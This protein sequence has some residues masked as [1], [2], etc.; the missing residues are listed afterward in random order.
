MTWLTP[1]AGLILAAVVIPPLVLLYFLKLRRK[2]QPIASTFLWKRAIEDLRANAPFQRLRRSILLLLQLIALI[3]LA[4]SLMQ[5]QIQGGDVDRGKVVILIDHSASMSAADVEDGGT[6]LDEAKRQARGYIESLYGGGIFASTN[7]EAMVIAFSDRAEIMCRFTGSRALLLDAVDRIEQT[8]GESSI[9]E[10]LKL[11]RAYTTNVDPENPRAV[12][13]GAHLELF[14]DGRIKDIDEQVLRDETMRYHAIGTP[15]GDNVAFSAVAIDRPY[16]QPTAVQVFAGLV[17]FGAELASCE[18][19]LSVDGVARHIETI[20]V[21]PAT[22]DPATNRLVPGR[23]NVAFSPFEQPRG[24]VFEL[25]NLRGDEL[26]VDN[27]AT[28]VVAPSKALRVGI[29]MAER[30][31]FLLT[32]LEGIKLERLEELTVADFQ[33]LADAGTIHPYDV[34]VLSGVK[35]E[36]LPVGRFLTFGEPPPVDGL[37]PFGEGDTQ[38]PLAVR[39]DHPVLRFV[40]MDPVRIARSVLIQ[41]ADNVEVLVD[42]SRGPLVVTGSDRSRHYVHVTFNPLDSTWFRRRSFPMFIL[43][44]V[45]YLGHLGDALSAQGFVPGQAISL[46]LPTDATNI[47]M[48][49]P[50]GDAISVDIA[51]DPESFTWGPVRRAGLYMISYD[52]NSASSRQTRPVAVNLISESE[53]DIHPAPEI[54]LSQDRVEGLRGSGAAYTPLWPWA[55]ALC[56]V[57]VMLE[58]WTYHRKAFV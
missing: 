6:R 45:E 55:V 36:Q 51:S 37:N 57:L 30:D 39:G 54:V 19:Q 29:V 43:N 41:P 23:N 3:L 42:G 20:D 15:E 9:E 47:S 40:Q 4:L 48:Q 2:P 10:A 53:G 12:A 44:A 52:T 28:I 25:A 35:V 56:L 50:T 34:I 7:A 58:W 26:A 17:N 11:A 31:P 24:A 21:G 14:S 5:P 38:L 32:A 46:R 33:A 22:I 16:D 13:E 1:T 49:P 8:H 18:V 27:V